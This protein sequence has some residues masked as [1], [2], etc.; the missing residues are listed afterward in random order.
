MDAGS[1]QTSVYWAARCSSR[2][3]LTIVELLVVCAV[4]AIL[5]GLLMPA[6]Q[7]AREQARN[8]QCLA[9]EREFGVAF[10][11]FHEARRRLPSGWQRESSDRIARSWAGQLLPYLEHVAIDPGRSVHRAAMNDPASTQE[12]SIF[13]CPSDVAE[14]QF[15]LYREI[16]EHESSFQTSETMLATLPLSNYLGVFGVS[17]PD[18]VS[19]EIG[20]GPFREFRGCRWEDLRRGVSN[21]ALL[22]ERT[23]RKLP[24]TWS[25]F[26]LDGEDAAGRVTGNACLGPN[27]D[28]ADECEFDS[29]HDEHINVLWGDGRASSVDSSV[30]RLVYQSMA[31]RE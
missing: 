2:R 10:H 17:D 16:G 7:I 4:L 21:V 28:D 20:E 8:L 5:V 12:L 26:P 13:Q 14:S 3:G 22:S 27:R 25:D 18:D 6:V 31:R 24:A 23:A 11:A 1:N 30:D 19:G 15:A 29:R 9:H